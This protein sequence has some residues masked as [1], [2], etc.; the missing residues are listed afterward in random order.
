MLTYLYKISWRF[1]NLSEIRL[2]K[3][4]KRWDWLWSRY[5]LVVKPT[6]FYV[7]TLKSIVPPCSI[8]I[9]FLKSTMWYTKRA[10]LL[11]SEFDSSNRDELTSSL[12]LYWL[13][14]I[15][16][17]LVIMLLVKLTIYVYNLLTGLLAHYCARVVGKLKGN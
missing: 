11:K 10:K 17:F 13:W 2:K 7:T 16:C 4:K 9:L 3:K 1:V 8:S 5:Y 14:W 12:S 6:S 15:Q